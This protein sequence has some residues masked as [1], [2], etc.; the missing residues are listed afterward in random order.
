MNRR[1]CLGACLGGLLKHA[2][3]YN[4]SDE[5]REKNAF[6]ARRNA[7]Q[8]KALNIVTHLLYLDVKP[9]GRQNLENRYFLHHIVGRLAVHVQCSGAPRAAI[10]LRCSRQM[11]AGELCTCA[12]AGQ[13]AMCKKYAFIHPRGYVP[14]A[15]D[16]LAHPYVPTV[17]R[18]R[19]APAESARRVTRTF[20]YIG[21]ADGA[22]PK[23]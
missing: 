21:Q 16:V 23:Y 8:G 4:R 13:Y 19:V 2:L 15:R 11:W 7:R 22:A 6:I 12:L 5:V 1:A 17:R 20:T 9:P 3:P 10:W 14:T 18:R